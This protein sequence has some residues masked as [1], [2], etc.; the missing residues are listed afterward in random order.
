MTEVVNLNKAPLFH[1]VAILTSF[2]S[3]LARATSTFC[4]KENENG[5]TKIHD[6]VDFGD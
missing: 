1:T 6:V 2:Q 5:D 3:S 4:V